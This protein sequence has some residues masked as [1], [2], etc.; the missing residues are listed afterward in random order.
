MGMWMKVLYWVSEGNSFAWREIKA[1]LDARVVFPL[2][3]GL[4]PRFTRLVEILEKVSQ[5]ETEVKSAPF[6]RISPNK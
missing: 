5:D 6:P 3:V 4:I 2:A 1:D